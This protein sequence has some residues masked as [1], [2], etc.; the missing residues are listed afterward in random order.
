MDDD[1]FLADRGKAVTIMFQNAFGKARRIWREFQR[2]PVFVHQLPK[3]ADA[4]E[5]DG[6]DNDGCASA[7]L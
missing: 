2:W 3:V 1:V 6:F 5:T 4:Q 7:K